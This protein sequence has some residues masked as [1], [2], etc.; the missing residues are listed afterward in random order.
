MS[1]RRTRDRELSLSRF[2]RHALQHRRALEAM[3]LGGQAAGVLASVIVARSVGPSGRGMLVTLTVWGQILGWLAAFSLDKALVVLTTG[4]TAVIS[5]DQGLRAVR[6]PVLAL[7][8]VAILA[9]FLLGRH[10]FSNIWLTTAMAVFVVATAQTELVSGWLLA[11]GRR[12]AFILWRLSQPMLY[13]AILIT[14]ALTLRS[15]NT[16]GRTVGMGFGAAASVVV[17]VIFALPFL[18]RR[19]AFGWHGIGPLL[20]FGAAAQVANILQYLNARLDFLALTFLVSAQSLGYYS[21]GASLGQVALLLA[22]AG[23]IRG[24]TGEADSI[25][26]VGLSVAALLAGIVIVASPVL[27][28]TIFGTS[29]EPA[30]PIARIL[31]IGAVLNYALQGS[32]GRLLNRRHPWILAASQGVGV[33]VFAIG[34]KAFPTLTGV[35]WSSVGSFIVSLLINQVALHV[36]DQRRVASP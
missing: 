14:L 26:R 20:R 6:P 9:A 18:P 15:A 4:N 32:S 29:F 1:E 24:I 31:A 8:S 34:I 3:L 28:P 10:F 7:S 33:V 21:V 22:S 2:V 16:Q 19:P 11:T 25:D 23:F 13:L 17:P 36:L 27:V 5:P 12:Q 30:V 35:A